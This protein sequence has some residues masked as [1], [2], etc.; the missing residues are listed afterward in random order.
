MSSAEVRE[1]SRKNDGEKGENT[2]PPINK[3][4][5]SSDTG[6]PDETMDQSSSDTA[7]LSI[8]SSSLLSLSEISDLPVDQDRSES[9]DSISSHLSALTAITDETVSY[10]K[11]ECARLKHKNKKLK[12]KIAAQKDDKN[13]PKDSEEHTN[14]LDTIIELEAK[15]TAERLLTENLKE[16]KASTQAS[17]AQ[18]CAELDSTR[19]ELH[20]EQTRREGMEEKLKAAGVGEFFPSHHQDKVTLLEEELE[21]VQFM[22]DEADADL[23]EQRELNKELQSTIESLRADLKTRTKSGCNLI[24]TQPHIVCFTP[25]PA[26]TRSNLAITEPNLVWLEPDNVEQV[27]SLLGCE[28]AESTSHL[29]TEEPHDSEAAILKME[30]LL[31]SFPAC[32]LAQ[33]TPASHLDTELD[34]LDEA[35][36]AIL[37]MEKTLASIRQDIT[38][39]EEKLRIQRNNSLQADLK[40]QPTQDATS[41]QHKPHIVCFTPDPATTRSNLAITEPNLVWFEPDNAEEP[42]T[43]CHGD[44]NTLPTS[45][46]N[47][48]ATKPHIVCFTPDPATIRSNLAITEPNLVWLEPDNVEPSELHSEQT[49]RQEM[50]EKLK[51][52]GVGEFFPSHHEDKVTLLEEE[53]ELVQFMKDE[54]DADL[55]EQKKLNK[56]LQKTIESLQADL[57]TR[58]NSG[59]NYNL[60][61]TQPHIVC[62][63]PDPATTRCNL[64]ITKPTLCGWNQTMLNNILDD[65]FPSGTDKL[66]NVRSTRSI[67]VG[68]EDNE[69][70][71]ASTRSNLAITKPNLVWLEP[72]N[73]EPRTSDDSNDIPT[74]DLDPFYI[75]QLE[76][77]LTAMRLNVEE[78]TTQLRTA[79]R[80]ID[81]LNDANE[82]LEEDLQGLQTSSNTASTELIAVKNNEM[83]EM[84]SK[85]LGANASITELQNTIDSLEAEIQELQMSLQA[86]LKT[87][88]NSGR[89]LVATKPHIV[90]F[91]PDQ[92]STRSNLAITEPN[93]VW[94]EPDNVLPRKVEY[95]EQELKSLTES[96]DKEESCNK[97]LLGELEEADIKLARR[98]LEIE[99]LKCKLAILESGGFWW[100]GPAH[101]DSESDTES[102]CS[103]D[104]LDDGFLSGT[105]K[106]DNVR[107]TRS[108]AVGTEDNETDSF[109]HQTMIKCQSELEAANITLAR[110]EL[111]IEDLK[112]KL[113]ILESGGIWW[114]SPAHA[115]SESDAESI[116]TYLS[117]SLDDAFRSGTDKLDNVTSTRSIA[118]GTEANETDHVARQTIS[119]STQTCNLTCQTCSTQTSTIKCKTTTSSTQTCNLTCKTT[120]TSTQTCNLTCK[121]ST[122]STQT[123]NLA[124]QTTTTSTQTDLTPKRL[125]QVLSVV[126]SPT[127]HDETVA[128]E[129][130]GPDEPRP[131]S[132]LTLLPPNAEPLHVPR[133]GPDRAHKL[134]THV[135]AGEFYMD[136]F[137]VMGGRTTFTVISDCELAVVQYPP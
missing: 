46:H 34:E 12:K 86:D 109:E 7:A 19:L 115:E 57:K 117:D 1:R 125:R 79:N 107:S 52:T 54:A 13:L 33:P 134:A 5:V 97:R 129:L 11:E 42:V 32:V 96:K 93:L 9:E 60:I 36:I 114:P 78:L 101:A 14:M 136:S 63:T 133:A 75:I 26:T 110:T 113:A 91:M 50:E 23:I 131:S 22:K 24:A 39:K 76:A 69:T 103:T 61:A 21:L 20:S 56:E 51:A 47:L 128:L 73:V 10:Y 67:A 126:M 112:C 68:T 105:N 130:F 43:S 123:C 95:L 132:G 58:P 127:S 66:D 106:P 64:A 92:A 3:E 104:S 49:G 31:E 55:M 81:E 88:P 124:S 137:K 98:E 38:N 89:N 2:T 77:E 4:V 65:A 59:C 135:P 30:K 121:T 90:C 6:I 102:I 82:N 17:L 16:E 18:L 108:I 70:D 37:G 119:S 27:T 53:L 116:S 72:D 87:R 120:T 122:S 25:D 84:R 48:A 83:K 94:L 71:P 100:H 44:Q 118:V 35:D 29:D 85:I 40:T 80:S 45:G 74:A 28:S 62:F 15:L 111:E 41:L 99:D 8:S